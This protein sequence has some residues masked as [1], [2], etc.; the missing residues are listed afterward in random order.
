MMEA[1]S[2]GMSYESFMSMPSTRRL[3]LIN[4][5]VELERER[6]AKQK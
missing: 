1:W 3:R 6:R 4:R 2:G 5:K